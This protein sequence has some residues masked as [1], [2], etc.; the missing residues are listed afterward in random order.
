MPNILKRPMFRKGGST[1]DGVGITSGLR[2]NYAEGTP[3]RL[4]YDEEKGYSIKDLEDAGLVRTGGKKPTETTISMPE[5]SS[6]STT[7]SDPSFDLIRSRY[8]ELA[9]S[10]ET[11]LQ[12]LITALGATAPED[13]TKLQTIG[14]FLSKAGTTA[15]GLRQQR[16]ATAEAFKSGALSE[17]LKNMNAQEKDQLIRRAKEFARINNI[18]EDQAINMFL[19][20]MLQSDSG[21]SE[22]LKDYSPGVRARQ[23]GEKL[24]EDGFT[25]PG[26]FQEQITAGNI[27]QLWEN[28]KLPQ[29]VQ[30]TLS[31]TTYPNDLVVDYE[32]GTAEFNPD[33]KG[34]NQSR[35]VPNKSY[36]NPSDGGVYLYEGDGQ[37]KKIYP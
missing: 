15:T 34:I 12:D 18:P 36:V 35:Y 8:E 13:A 26:S 11:N 7:F 2:K 31:A 20:K 10:R 28:K 23:I 6:P 5:P 9:P 3:K 21:G 33:K 14:Q 16:E 22:F 37:F 30:E 17:V 4:E 1:S 24:A 25:S 32:S 29:Q 19:S 27:W